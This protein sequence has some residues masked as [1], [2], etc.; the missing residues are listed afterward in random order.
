MEAGSSPPPTPPP[1]S[2]GPE[3][4]AAEA[5]ALLP[6]FGANLEDVNGPLAILLGYK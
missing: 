3:P 1:G 4:G 5:V 2:A 6:P